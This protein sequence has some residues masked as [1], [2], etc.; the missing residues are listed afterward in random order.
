VLKRRKR[1]ELPPGFKEIEKAVQR[2][3]PERSLL[4]IL[5]NTQHWINWTRHFQHAAGTTPKLAD[6]EMRYVIVTF[7]WGTNLGPAQGARHIKFNGNGRPPLTAHALSYVNRRHVTAGK[8]DGAIRDHIN[9]FNALGLPKTWGDGKSAAADGTTI[10]LY[11]ENLIVA[12]QVRHGKFGGVAYHHISNN[13][14]ALISHFI[15]VGTSEAL[16]ILEGL[17]K[18]TSDIQPD[19]VHADSH[20]QNEPAFG[21]AFLLKIA[22]EPRIKRWKHLKFYRP[23]KTA[24][25][26]HIDPLFSDVVD[27]GL[28][29]RHWKDLMQVV[30]SMKAG[31]ISSPMVLRKLGQRFQ[32]NIT[33]QLTLAGRR[34]PRST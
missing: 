14:I 29:Y 28:L 13:W 24:H 20:G 31:R 34:A 7:T 25:Y 8:L 26:K 22:L 18:N 1:R 19:T 9:F 4:E 33:L 30:L 17:L 23:R 21:L 12:Y 27:W 32:N 15:P 11:D 3:M 2:R 6:P 16:Y 5:S 10:D